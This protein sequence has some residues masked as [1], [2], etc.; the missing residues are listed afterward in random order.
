M[1]LP[2]FSSGGLFALA[3]I[4]DAWK[5]WDGYWLQT[6]AIMTEANELKS[7]AHL[8]NAAILDPRMKM[9]DLCPE[10]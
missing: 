9:L 5:D 7:K 8:R 1:H 3:G 10:F 4:W 6:Y 2:C